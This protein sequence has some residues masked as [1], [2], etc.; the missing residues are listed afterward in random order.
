[1]GIA[2]LVGLTSLI[3]GFQLYRLLQSEKSLVD[4]SVPSLINSQ[5]LVGQL[6][7]QLVLTSRLEVAANADEVDELKSQLDLNFDR[8]RVAVGGSTAQES[9]DLVRAELPVYLTKLQLTTNKLIQLKQTLVATG[10]RVL[11]QRIELLEQE[12]RLHDTTEPASTLLANQL[13][14]TLAVL[15][16]Q[17]VHNDKQI[18]GQLSGLLESENR[19]REINFQVT[20]AIDI[21]KQLP[22]RPDANLI[23]SAVTR[24]Q[25]NLRS[26]T[27]LL[28]GL[29]DAEVKKRFAKEIS[30]LRDFL[31][32]ENQLIPSLRNFE[33]SERQFSQQLVLQQEAAISIS[34]SVDSIVAASRQ[35]TEDSSAAFE[36]ILDN[37]VLLQFLLALLIATIAAATLYFL[38]EKQINR[39]MAKL[40]RT[41]LAIA[42]GNLD[43]DVD[44]RGE[45]EIAEMAESLVIFR[46]NARELVRSNEELQTFA[47][48][49]SHDLKSPL[50]AI[51][52]LVQW[53]LEDG[54]DDL[55]EDSIRNLKL[56]LSR[57]KRLS[58]LQTGLLEYARVGRQEE[59]SDA[60]NLQEMVSELSELLDPDGHYPITLTSD[61]QSIVTQVTPLKQ[62]LMNL[63]SNAIK[64]HD[65]P[66]GHISITVLRD[67]PRLNISVQDDGP[68]I[69]LEYQDRVFGL[70]QTLRSR[71][72]VE[73]SGLGLSL[74]RKQIE[75]Y[76][77]KI[78]LHSDPS[79]QRGTRFTF[80]FPD[81]SAAPMSTVN[82]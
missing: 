82:L 57:T 20:R 47:Y 12:A 65:R 67:F 42:A 55:P 25:F 53:T 23:D 39:R 28:L 38:V 11:D 19:I 61:T 58:D 49:A 10:Q 7:T 46:R 2:L 60:I 79:V 29:S 1:M 15:S 3:G 9:G 69:E 32:S 51:E 66:E 40:T 5:R 14:E 45:D 73:G 50:R 81:D 64:H 31:F 80:D 70:F 43:R 22:I 37:T 76:G 74:V 34:E 35:Q 30:A 75:H 17:K 54:M 52:H 21:A 4:R 13:D 77:G 78:V 44:T 8:L 63:I 33:D 59:R 16:E 6:S 26:A 36:S 41:V 56:A 71:D 18:A 48:A 72:E 62:I 27:Q 24:I 68:G